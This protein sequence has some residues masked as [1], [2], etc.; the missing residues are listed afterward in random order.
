MF[1]KL[2]DAILNLIV[3][4]ERW[5]C[6]I[7]EL[8]TPVIKIGTVIS[9]IYS[10]L[11]I[12]LL[13]HKKMPP[14]LIQGIRNLPYNQEILTALAVISFA[15]LVLSGGVIEAL[16][17]FGFVTDFSPEPRDVTYDLWDDHS[18]IGDLLEIILILLPIVVV[19][20]IVAC[21]PTAFIIAHNIKKHYNA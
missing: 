20:V 1:K 14:A 12:I 6:R 21:V 7:Q 9:A 8:L 2:G 16:H 11:A 15:T 18:L 13:F 10:V 19:T 5:I 4:L 3:I 17:L